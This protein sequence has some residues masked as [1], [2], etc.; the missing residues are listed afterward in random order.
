V[1]VGVVVVALTAG[2][3]WLLTVW[4]GAVRANTVANPTA[5]IAPSWVTCQVSRD[6][7]FSPAVRVAS[8]GSSGSSGRYRVWS[9]GR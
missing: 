2:A 7:R 3:A 1:G 6:S 9:A 5:V 8:G 4:A